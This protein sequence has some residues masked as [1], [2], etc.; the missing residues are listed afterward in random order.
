MDLSPLEFETPAQVV[1]ESG[2]TLSVQCFNLQ[3][4]F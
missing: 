4:L 3:K 2:T 1:Q